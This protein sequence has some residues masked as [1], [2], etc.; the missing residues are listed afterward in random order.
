MLTAKN[1][2]IAV[3]GVISVYGIVGSVDHAPGVH[4][5]AAVAAV[6]A[7]AAPV[8]LALQHWLSDP[9]TGNATTPPAASATLTLT[10]N[11][12]AG[13]AVT[14]EPAPPAP[15]EQPSVPSGA[16]VQSTPAPT[17]APVP[18]PE[19]PT[20]WATMDA[21]PVATPSGPPPANAAPPAPGA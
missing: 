15:T 3:A 5:P 19:P 7:A 9:S 12:T 11:A 10:S 1:V 17:P 18:A 8:M 2:R 13:K 6:L 4:L 21:S 16:V 14:I 20:S